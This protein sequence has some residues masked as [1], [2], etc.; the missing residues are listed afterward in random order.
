MKKEGN[1]STF[2][3]GKNK[4]WVRSDPKKTGTSPDPG[5]MGKLYILEERSKKMKCRCEGGKD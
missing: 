1:K 5:E 2:Y 3:R 4:L